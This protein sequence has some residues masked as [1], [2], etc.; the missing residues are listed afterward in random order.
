MEYTE[1]GGGEVEIAGGNFKGN[2]GVS[3]KSS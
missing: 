3:E 2:G 1:G